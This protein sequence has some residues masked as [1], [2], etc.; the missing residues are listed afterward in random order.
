M[1]AIN[2]SRH[3][4][5]RRAAYAA[6]EHLY[7]WLAAAR[8]EQPE[9]VV[10]GERFTPETEPRFTDPRAAATYVDQVLAHLRDRDRGYA[11]RERLPVRVRARAGNQAAGYE[12]LTTTIALPSYEVGGRWALRGLVVLHELAHHLT[13]D[14]EAGHGPAWRAT[15][16]R[17]LE[18][19]GSP[20]LAGL[21]HRAF[22]AEGLD[23]VGH[24]TGADT[25]AKIAK[26]LRQA[27]RSGND[28]ERDAFLTKAQG[29]ATRHSVALAVARAHTDREERRQQLVAQTCRIGERGKRGL[30]RYVQLL[31]NIAHANDLR[32]TISHDNTAVHLH[33][34]AADVEV[35]EAMYQ[36]LLVQMV[37]DCERY[38]AGRPEELHWVWDERR[39]WRHKPV[40]TI[41]A[42][43]AFYQA[44]AQRI[45]ARLDEARQAAVRA[46]ERA[47]ADTG[48]SGSSTELALRQKEVDIHDFFAEVLARNNIRGTWRGG[49]GDGPERAPGAAREG[50][51]AADRARLEGE[52]AIG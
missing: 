49:R 51:R 44:F 36:S 18:D 43:L 52:R 42:R 23:A 17:L 16:V 22:R 33:G 29:L 1:V 30:A 12:R 45:G 32:C 26:L 13:E 14:P 5:D 2:Q 41:T 7:G 25:V 4:P 6:E 37:A 39:G 20:V 21:L 34:F 35:T 3:D 8:P 24:E 10:D 48:G 11:G 47:E 31:L 9:I 15:Y 19:V 28:N 27:E 38:L 50:A 46:A 40:A